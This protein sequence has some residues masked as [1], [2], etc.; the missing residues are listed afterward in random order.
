MI[1]GATELQVRQARLEITRM[2]DE[3]TL[4]LGGGG[5]GSS[6]RYSVI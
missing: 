2:L 3:E 4:K 5:G 6:S 1:E